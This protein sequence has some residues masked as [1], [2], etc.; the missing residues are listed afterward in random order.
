MIDGD[1]HKE[2]DV[3]NTLFFKNVSPSL[4]L[5]L[6]SNELSF[7]SGRNNSIL[8]IFFRGVTNRYP[9]PALIGLIAKGYVQI[10]LVDVSEK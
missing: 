6:I 1:F 3:V 8:P 4:S 9:P 7:P 10:V 2:M 5:I